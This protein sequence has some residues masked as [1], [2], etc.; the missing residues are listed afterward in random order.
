MFL[1]IWSRRVAEVKKT[2]QKWMSC[3][4]HHLILVYQ[5]RLKQPDISRIAPIWGQL[6]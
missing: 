5:E 1:R 2:I 4:P 3:S 6:S